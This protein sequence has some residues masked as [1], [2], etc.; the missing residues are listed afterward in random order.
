MNILHRSLDLWTAVVLKW[1]RRV[2][3]SALIL[4]LASLALAAA[5][6]G[7]VTNRL[8]LISPDN[9]L[10][11]VSD[12]LDPFNLGGKDAFMVV[13]QAPTPKRA[14]TFS[15]VLAGVIES[16]PGQFQNVYYRVDPALIH[17][18][19]L[20]Y[21]N[22]A[23]LQKI[24]DDLHRYSDLIQG[25]AAQPDLL[26]FL[27][28][29]DRKMTSQM[30]SHLFTGF[31][32]KEEHK[33]GGGRGMKEED[34]NLLIRTFEGLNSYLSG[35]PRYRSPWK[36]LLGR[37][38]THLDEQGYFWQGGKRYLLM[39]VVLN[40]KGGGFGTSQVRL[41]R[42]RKLIA[43]TRLS[44]SDVHAGVT[45]EKAMNTDQMTTALNDMSHATWISLL[46]VLILLV[47]FFR[48]IRRP[49]VQVIALGVG[50]CW[51]FGWTTLFI[52]HLN[53]LSVVFAPL[54][55]GLGV[56]Y[57]I[58][59]F[60]RFEEEERMK[61]DD[62]A[63]VIKRVT[64]RSGP[65]IFLAGVATAFSLLPLVFT[66][67]AGL[68][69]LGLITG[70]GILLIV[71]ADFTVLPALSVLQVR[72]APR[73][74]TCRTLSTEERNLLRFKR[75]HAGLVLGLAGILCVG[76]IL[77][78][79]EVRF[80][81]NPMRLE[82][83]RAQSVIW[84][85]RLLEGSKR[86]SISAAAFAS[87]PEEVKEKVQE[88]KKLSSVAE[89]ES[90]YSILPS[91]QNEKL[92]SVRAIL[93]DL[94]KP[95]S[96]Q[97]SAEPNDANE[98]VDILERIRF[99]LQLNEAKKS[100]ANKPLL[101][102]MARLDG[103]SD[104]IIRKL[105]NDS[106]DIAPQLTAYR[107]R[108]QENLLHTWHFFRSAAPASPM[109]IHDIP[110]YLRH[111][112]YDKGEY[113]IRIY[114]KGSIWNAGTLGSF[115]QQLKGVDPE[116]AGDPVFLYAFASAFKRACMEASIY[117]LVSVF[118]ILTVSF[119]SIALS[120]LALMPLAVGTIWVVGIMG[121]AG[122]D[123]NLANSIFMPLIIGAGVEY[124][125]IILQRWREGN[126]APGHLPMSTGKG[127]ILAA[128]T[129]TTGFGIL[130]ISHD[131]GIFSLG[132]VAG[133]GSICVLIA[134]LVLLPAALTFIGHSKFIKT[135][136]VE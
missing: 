117:A 131:R 3:A 89:V 59:W 126:I 1:P 91:D 53:I 26:Q 21:A 8:S 71:L 4:A 136:R 38:F 29:V 86:S 106:P 108:F 27:R 30:V 95:E 15:R 121:L 123:F 122:I 16:Y 62:R 109:T 33:N 34:L 32:N 11:K 119:R 9:P 125:V 88:F 65:A 28:I 13:I 24:Q 46:G 104:Q 134:A 70:V 50:I 93:K 19:A 39:L 97:I 35:S 76:S 54:L 58:H 57:A 22:K 135:K 103:L 99:K 5:K 133:I 81:L 101:E 20:L 37:A 40:E 7:V 120:L 100:G 112:F 107:E 83:P 48:G 130:M 72:R 105:R 98:L 75:S 85:R 10:V 78:S 56:D 80:D 118:I 36:S 25:L 124:G 55:I 84:E 49:L 31:L 102:K 127:V 17:P 96:T 64:K 132:F 52:G 41:D 94:P 79:M 69:E 2:L 116:V 6:L 111:R 61:G 68:G 73:S 47:L 114:P 51:T 18:W 66:S 12:K 44:F 23:Q 43:Q 87:S 42:L 67:F 14:I 63:S 90:I 82:N 129:T 110:A 45:G 128:L 77:S 74:R 60:A 92:P 113:L 115:V